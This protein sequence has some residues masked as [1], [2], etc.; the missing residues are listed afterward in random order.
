MADYGPLYQSA[1]Q[2]WNI[3]P[4]LLQ[5]I[6]TQESGQG[7]NTGPSSAGA[8]GFMQ[9]MPETAARYKVDVNS[10]TSS[11]MGAAHY[12]D[13]LLQYYGGDLNAALS[14]YGGDTSGKAGYAQS[15]VNRYRQLRAAWSSQGSDDAADTASMQSPTSGDVGGI[16]ITAHALPG[17]GGAQQGGASFVPPPGTPDT[18]GRSNQPGSRA[19]HPMQASEYSGSDQPPKD[20]TSALFGPAPAQQQQPQGQQASPVPSPAP[21]PATP[22]F[23]TQLFGPTGTAGVTPQPDRA[24]A[25]DVTTPSATSASAAPQP[26][27]WETNVAAP[28]R[29]MYDPTQGGPMN[30]LL[31]Q[32]LLQNIGAGVLQGPRNVAQRAN[33]WEQAA[34]QNYPWL[35][36]LD[37]SVG[38]TPDVLAARGKQLA[39]Q[40]QAYRTQYGNSLPAMAGE[41]AGNLL[42]TYPLAAIGGVLGAVGNAVPL[43]RGTTEVANLA[44]TPAAQNILT[45]PGQDWRTAGAE[46]A[47]GGLA[48]GGGLGS[49]AGQLAPGA[50]SQAVKEAKD[51]GFDLTTGEA[52]GG[53]AKQVED[54][55]QYLPFSGA[56]RKAAEHREVIN[57][58]LNKNMGMADAGGQVNQA[59]MQLARARAGNLMDQIQ[60]VTVDANKDPNLLNDLGQIHADAAA[61]PMTG[62]SVTGA[63]DKV[64]GSIDKNGMLTGDV[65]H[66]LIKSGAPLDNLI[67][68]RDPVVSQFAQRVKTSLL[69]AASR[70]DD[71]NI[72]GANQAARNRQAVADFN[73]GRYYWKTIKTV[74]PLVDKT[75]SADD[76]SYAGLARRIEGTSQ[77]PN[78]DPRFP[79]QNQQMATLARVLRGPLAELKS[80]GT[81]RQMITGQMLGLG[82]EA[83]G[84]TAL[85]RPENF[86]Q[87]LSQVA[88]PTLASI[89]GGR[90]LRYGPGMGVPAV[91]AANQLFNPLLPRVAGPAVAT[92]PLLNPPQQGQ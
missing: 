49:I 42:T 32:P 57:S 48:V 88:A 9:F 90:L 91:E 71:P 39:A 61:Q 69:D 79:G 72:Y 58:I 45:T 60:K 78:F 12:M 10:P 17:P 59:T 51:L 47:A 86:N 92:N 20:F 62:T 83:G 28:V 13:D 73:D 26:S 63:V 66:N 19:S 81:G 89:A 50:A 46:G 23:Q 41:V 31:G 29:S 36:N 77:N 18:L 2:Q 82:G 11:V 24:P 30:Y 64:I 37:R 6:A 74:E 5:S 43:L 15:V 7:A 87:Y 22:D 27:W 33:E 76:A 70:G 67:N 85:F 53:L 65:L 34:D 14:A 75:G 3:D 56:A 25:P 52:A 16:K 44:A 80:S 54:V 68:S 55:T 21:A 40:T 1:G 35:A 4:L 84:L 8:K 38:E